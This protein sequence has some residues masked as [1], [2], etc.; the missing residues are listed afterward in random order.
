MELVYSVLTR[1]YV[2]DGSDIRKG[3]PSLALGMTMFLRVTRGR[4]GDSHVK[5]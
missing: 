3:D 2:F 1:R 4:S 5:S